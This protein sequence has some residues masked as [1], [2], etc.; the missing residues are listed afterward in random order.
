LR[1]KEAVDLI[2]AIEAK[3]HGIGGRSRNGSVKTVSPDSIKPGNL[4]LWYEEFSVQ[5]DMKTM[6]DGIRPTMSKAYIGFSTAS[7]DDIFLATL[8]G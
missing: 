2:E 7:L 6:S 1:R 5:I 4:A 8:A 3:L